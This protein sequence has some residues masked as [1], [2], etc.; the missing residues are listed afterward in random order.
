[1]LRKQ[2]AR[3]SKSVAETLIREEL[4]KQPNTDDEDSDFTEWVSNKKDS[5]DIFTVKERSDST[6][7]KTAFDS[8]EDNKY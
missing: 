5:S 1:M 6:E 4:K 3:K 7:R 2:P 8:D